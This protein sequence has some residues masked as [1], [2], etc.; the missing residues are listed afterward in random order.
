MASDDDVEERG[1]RK[2]T[3][4]QRVLVGAI[5][6]LMAVI[7]K[8]LGQDHAEFINA[9]VGSNIDI[10][11][12]TLVGFGIFTPLLMFLG[13][14]LAWVSEDEHNRRKLLAIGVAAP[15]LITTWIGG[16]FNIGTEDKDSRR[17]A[18]EQVAP[19]VRAIPAA[20]V[21]VSET[22]PDVERESLLLRGIKRF[23]NIYDAR[24]WVIIASFTD[25]DDAVAFA[26]RVRGYPPTR[27]VYVGIIGPWSSYF[28][29]FAA[30]GE[31]REAATKRLR[32]VQRI[33]A[34]GRNG[35]FLSDY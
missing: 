26:D 20:F 30:P 22:W 23:L 25:R 7:A 2:L 24:Y 32:A 8:Y 33:P 18:L 21:P 29:V 6:G 31:T 4:G 3:S 5:G 17:A 9:I 16:D 27:Q 34:I 13:A 14:G 12:E 10:I 35:P 11:K 15:A 19:H 1:V 28:P